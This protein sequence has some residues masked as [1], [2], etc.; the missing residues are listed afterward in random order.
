MHKITRQVLGITLADP[1]EKECG[2]NLDSK[3]FQALCAFKDAV[4]GL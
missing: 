1:F 2:S 3:V 4:L